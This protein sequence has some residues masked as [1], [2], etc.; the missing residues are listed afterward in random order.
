MNLFDGT[1]TQV[2]V[3][4]PDVAG[5]AFRQIWE[6]RE[7]DPMVAEILQAGEVLLLVHADTIRAPQ[8]VVD[9]A[10]L[11]RQLGIAIP[12]GAEVPWH[13]RLAPTQVQLVALLQLMCEPPL[14]VGP[15]RLAI[16][17]SAWDKARDE[18]LSPEAFLTAKMPL[19][20]QYLRGAADGWN[21]QVYGVSA[22][23]GDYDPIEPNAP[24]VPEAEKLRELDRP[25]M[26]ISLIGGEAESHDLT[27]PLAWLVG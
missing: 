4:F 23:G 26:R 16:M 12:D 10:A 11:S 5:E 8:W 1:D 2:R 9:V 19:L 15:R 6:E 18:G 13:P 3:T 25:S 20:D 17:L 24:L 14:D 7:C 22:Q 27:E 21:W